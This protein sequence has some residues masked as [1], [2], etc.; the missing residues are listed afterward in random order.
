MHPFSK[1][2]AILAYIIFR[3]Q[4]RATRDELVGLLWG[5]PSQSDGRRALRQVVYQIR[6]AT[7]RELWRGMRS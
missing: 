7:D 1:Q 3:P 2:L 4:A 5:D 6:H